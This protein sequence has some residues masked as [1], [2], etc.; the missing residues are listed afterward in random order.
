MSSLNQ[1]SFIGNVG[2]SPELRYTP[3]GDAMCNFSI[4]INESWNDK[5]TGQKREET[6]WV[7]V[8][9]YRKLAEICG[10][11]LSSG[12]QVFVQGKMKTKKFQDKETGADRYITEIVADQ[13]RL[14]GK[15]DD[16]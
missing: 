7:R 2:K 14:L 5:E 15:K 1:C 10:Q 3:G 16:S 4:A 11:L 13:M 6:E 8:V 9:A 12:K